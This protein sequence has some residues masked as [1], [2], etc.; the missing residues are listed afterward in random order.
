[1]RPTFVPGGAAA[2]KWITVGAVGMLVAAGAVACAMELAPPPTARV[3]RAAVSVSVSASGA[4]SAVQAQNLGFGTGGE[5]EELLVTVGDVVVP[6]QVLARIDDFA[7]QQALAQARA[8]LA[9]Q[10]AQLDKIVNGNSVEQAQRDLDAARRVLDATNAQAEAQNEQADSAVFRAEKELE[11]AEKQLRQAKSALEACE[12]QPIPPADMCASQQQAV[13]SAKQQ[14]VMAESQLSSARAQREVTEESGRLSV[15]N[16][17][18]S[19]VQAEN[20]LD[21]ARRNNPADIAAQRAAVRNAAVQVTIA[22]QDV[23][24]TTLRAPIG[25]TVASINGGVG[26]FVGQGTSV[27]PLAPGSTAAIPGVSAAGGDQG[28]GATTV[29]APGGSNFM[30]I[31]AVDAFQVVVPFEESDA[32]RVQPGQRVEVT[33]DAIPDLVR[34]GSVLAVAPSGTSI[35]G[36]TNYYV[37]VVLTETDPRLRD[38]QTAEADVLTEVADNVLSVPNAA[39]V[40]QG[41]QTFVNV[42]GAEDEPQQVPFEAG[43]QGDERTEVRSGLTEGQDVLLPQAT[44]IA[45]PENQGPPR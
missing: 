32:A 8:Q 24:N 2:K 39:V 4:L 40:R 41:A 11:L 25:G 31:G 33:F 27:T 10:Q 13:S 7:A 17:R 23:A 26:D 28:G 43:L 12:S 30:V 44:V 20:S 22:Q 35:S 14:V 6:G 18:R 1:M 16:A 38:R 34:A 21:A 15:E 19:V 29:S 3:E 9:Q 37:T 5:L 42:P 45:T 36:V